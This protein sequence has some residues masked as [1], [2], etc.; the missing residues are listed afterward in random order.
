MEKE[1]T[2]GQLIKKA[3]EEKGLTQIQLAEMSNVTEPSIRKYE[4]GKRNPKIN[5]VI[6]IAK[7]LDKPLTYFEL[8]MPEVEED[9]DR[10]K[11][12]SVADIERVLY[13]QV[14]LLAENSKECE[15]SELVEMTNCIANI[16][17]TLVTYQ[18]LKHNIPSAE[19]VFLQ[20]TNRIKESLK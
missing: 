20:A 5:T 11:V 13:K 18:D 17:T 9:E 4:C 15:P 19:E 7:A 8:D 12:N 14:E 3:R 16:Y 6:A 2:L 10:I 1:K